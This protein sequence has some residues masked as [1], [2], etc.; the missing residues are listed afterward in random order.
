MTL[1]NLQGLIFPAKSSNGHETSYGNV[2]S[3][4]S[5]SLNSP[6]LL[7]L[8]LLLLL[9]SLLLLLYSVTGS[10]YICPQVSSTDSQ[11]NADRL[12]IFLI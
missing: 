8:L 7:L 6:K 9:L 3:S 11:K 1:K 4:V 10:L 2:R 5:I 12:F